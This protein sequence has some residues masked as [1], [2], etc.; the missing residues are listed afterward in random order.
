MSIARTRSASPDGE[1]AGNATTFHQLG[2]VPHCCVG[3]GIAATSL[4]WALRPGRN[5]SDNSGLSYDRAGLGWSGACVTARTPSVIAA[6]LQEALR[7]AGLP[8][9]YAWSDT[10]LEG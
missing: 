7:V 6:E 9:P 1:C 2:W 10:P 4:S 3:S 5:A 8:G